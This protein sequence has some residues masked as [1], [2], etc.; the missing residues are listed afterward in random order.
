MRVLIAEDDPGIRD[1]LFDPE[2]CCEFDVFQAV[3]VLE[4]LAAADVP[5]DDLVRFRAN[6]SLSFPPS[7]LAQVIPPVPRDVDPPT[8]PP[9][10][11]P[12]PARGRYAPGHVPIVGAPGGVA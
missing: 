3:V 10:D 7:P 9:F 8:A 2:R 4:H 11:A 6:V 5:V 12:N 1:L